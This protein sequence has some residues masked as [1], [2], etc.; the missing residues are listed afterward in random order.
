MDKNF[1]LKSVRDSEL[2]HRSQINDSYH[3][4]HA[5]RKTLAAPV[6]K[7]NPIS[8]EVKEILS[9]LPDVSFDEKTGKSSNI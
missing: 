9:N 6:E 1:S 5:P 4:A 3:E 7:V 2:K 8:D